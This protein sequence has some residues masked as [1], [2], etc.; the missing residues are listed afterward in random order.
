M[1]YSLF[2]WIS[3]ILTGAVWFAIN[4]LFTMNLLK[5]VILKQPRL[6]VW[7]IL[8]VKFPLLYLIGFLILKAMIFPAYGLLIGVT[9]ILILLG[10]INASRKPLH[11]A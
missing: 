11:A 4:I 5:I 6:R 10:V 2:S 1:N 3:G 8:F 7:L 9:L